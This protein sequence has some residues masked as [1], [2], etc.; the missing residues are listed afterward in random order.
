MHRPDIAG[1][2]DQDVAWRIGQDAEGGI[3]AGV[4][5]FVQAFVTIVGEAA[6]A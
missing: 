2:I 3:D 5:I 6:F 1:G 4:K